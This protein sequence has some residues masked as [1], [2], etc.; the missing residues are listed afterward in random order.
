MMDGVEAEKVKIGVEKEEER[1]FLGLDLSTQQ[2]KG[3]FCDWKLRVVEEVSVRFD[4][5]LPEFRTLGGVTRE[6]DIGGGGD[7]VTCP[8]VMWVKALDVLLEKAKGLQI[9]LERVVCISGAAQQHGTVYWKVGD[10]VVLGNLAPDKTLFEQFSDKDTFCIK[11][12]PVWMDSSTDEESQ[13]LES[14]ISEGELMTLTGSRAHLRI[15]AVQIMKLIRTRN[16]EMQGCERISMISSFLCSLLL[17]KYAPIDYADGSGMNLLNIHKKEW[18]GEIIDFV[19]GY[20]NVG[21]FK[22]N[23]TD[24]LGEP[25]PSYENLGSISEYFVKRYGFNASCSVSAFTGDNPASLMGFGLG[26]SDVCVSMGTSDTV[27]LSLRELPSQLTDPQLSNT[28]CFLVNPSDAEAYMGLVCFKNGSLVRESVRNAYS[29]SSW[30][31]FNSQLSKTE[32][33]NSGC[34]GVYYL[35]QEITPKLERG[36][37]RWEDGVFIGREDGLVPGKSGFRK[38]NT[39]ARAVIESQMLARR[40]Y[41]ET[42]GIKINGSTRLLATGGASANKT[43][44]QVMSNVFGLP[45]WVLENPNSASYGAC[46]LAKLSYLL[47]ATNDKS[48]GSVRKLKADLEKPAS[49]ILATPDPKVAS[50]YNTLVNQYKAI[51]KQIPVALAD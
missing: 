46:A 10:G 5:E 38:E 15:S 37:Y 41:A 27:L 42:A 12:S 21:G 17:G 26:E 13:A 51:E 45:V 7:T 20:G 28:T 34:T 22:L 6:K 31:I 18:V 36:I 4:E 25:V 30:E 1:L 48:I 2:L 47:K 33:G 43:I 3:A 35:Q 40:V 16:A 32:P 19:A 49:K 14:F 50:L 9:P 23:L 11:Q 39:E 8:T 24:L 29:N 44:L